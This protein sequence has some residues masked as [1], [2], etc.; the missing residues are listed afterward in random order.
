[1][2]SFNKPFILSSLNIF[3]SLFFFFVLESFQLSNLPM[4]K[5]NWWPGTCPLMMNLLEPWPG[6]CPS[7]ENRWTA[8]QLPWPWT[9][10]EFYIEFCYN[11]AH[12]LLNFTWCFNTLFNF[13]KI[14]C[15]QHIFPHVSPPPQKWSTPTCNPPQFFFLPLKIFFHPR[16]ICSTFHICFHI[17]Y[18]SPKWSPPT[19]WL[20]TP[21]KIFFLPPKFFSY[22]PKWLP[23]LKAKK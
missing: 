7:M 11:C 19:S 4:I 12:M 16:L 8:D 23:L 17:C 6:T 18:P 13:S 21:P 2:S 1:M 22:P 9:F 3:S 14:C 10:I 5:W 15:I 20:A